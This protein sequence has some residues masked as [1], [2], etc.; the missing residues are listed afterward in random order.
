MAGVA[1]PVSAWSGKPSVAL[2]DDGFPFL[3]THITVSSLFY[4]HMGR[5]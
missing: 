2:A 1:L 3:I 4:K 5:K